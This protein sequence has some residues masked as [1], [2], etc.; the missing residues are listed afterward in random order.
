MSTDKNTKIISGMS[1]FYLV[2]Y[3]LGVL[4]N[5]YVEN[6]LYTFLWVILFTINLGLLI[7][8]YRKAKQDK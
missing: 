6:Y 8:R 3:A 2:L 4:Y 7:F 5:V 1:I